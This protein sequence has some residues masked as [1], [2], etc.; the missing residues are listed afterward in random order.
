MSLKF[1][2][3]RE[4][5]ALKDQRAPFSPKMVQH[6]MELY[7][8]AH[9]EVESSSNRIFSDDE[10]KHCGVAI[11]SSCTDCDVFIGINPV[12]SANL[13]PKKNYLFVTDLIHADAPL[14]TLDT[15]ISLVG[16]YNAFRAF[17]MK[18]E[19]FKLPA[20][21]TFSDQASLI[22]YLKRIVLPPLKITVIGS[23][24]KL[25]GTDRILK[26]IK[27]KKVNASDFLAKNYAQAVYT[28]VDGLD[29]ETLTSLTKV[30]D[31]FIVVSKIG[32][33]EVVV[34]QD[35]LVQKDCKIRVL[36]DLTPSSHNLVSCTVRQS[37]FEAPFYGYLPIEHKE[38][39]IFHPAAIV[40]VALPDV[41][42][43]FPRETSEYIGNQLTQHCIPT[44]FK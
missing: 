20:V 5:I 32:S 39:D 22:S 21:A 30:S 6:L 15:L 31:I 34:S 9:F 16:T 43:E 41:T 27:I 38:V 1:G 14:F 40:V 10:Y 18:F 28:V 3:V 29:S 12:N 11:V 25:L 19:L 17:G 24:E 35:M 44:F 8:N 23:D 13:I 33:Q 37:T 26:A 36:A 7:P 2:I 42:T 4:S